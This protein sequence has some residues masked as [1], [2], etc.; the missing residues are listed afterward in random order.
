MHWSN[1]LHQQDETKKKGYRQGADS[2]KRSCPVSIS[3]ILTLGNNVF[4]P[5]YK[6]VDRIRVHNIV[7]S[8]VLE[9][10]THLIDE[11]EQLSVAKWP[12]AIFDDFPSLY[13]IS[14]NQTTIY[15][16]SVYILL[17]KFTTIY[18]KNTI[19]VIYDILVTLFSLVIYFFT[20]Q[21]LKH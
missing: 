11:T 19:V 9:E 12:A 5:I 20:R 10:K 1:F 16:H 13:D 14:L 17:Y 8:I 21:P 7:Y 2:E 15:C 6:W 4:V 3:N 18:H